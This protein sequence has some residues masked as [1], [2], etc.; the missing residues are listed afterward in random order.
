MMSN[1]AERAAD[2]LWLRHLRPWVIEV[3]GAAM[4]EP[5]PVGDEEQ[6]VADRVTRQLERYREKS[7]QPARQRR[8]AK[9]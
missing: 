1:S 3:I 5:E 6:Y 9:P 8:S 2:I 4:T 7:R